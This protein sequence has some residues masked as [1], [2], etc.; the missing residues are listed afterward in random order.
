MGMGYTIASIGALLGNPIAG[1]ARDSD[2]LDVLQRWQGAWF[3][4]GSA[5]FVATALMV[6]TRL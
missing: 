6:L 1:L 3:V 4:A 2:S 5:L